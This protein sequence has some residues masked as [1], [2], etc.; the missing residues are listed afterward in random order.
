MA[1]VGLTNQHLFIFF[2]LPASAK[3]LQHPFKICKQHAAL[4]SF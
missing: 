3:N 4:T 1:L 2:L